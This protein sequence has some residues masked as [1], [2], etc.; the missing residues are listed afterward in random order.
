[1]TTSEIVS[2]KTAKAWETWLARNHAKSSGVWLR[3]AKKDSGTK[4]VSYA[5]ALD[6]A[7]C[8]GW[9]DGQKGKGDEETWLQRFTPR[10]ARS[11]WSRI[12][13]DKALALIAEG[14]MKAAGLAEV[15]RAKRDGRWDA[16]YEPQHTST[17]PPD[18]EAALNA[19]PAA[20]AFFKTLDSA[21]RY[22]ILWRIA[23]AKKAETRAK[24]IATFVAMLARG[25][26]IHEK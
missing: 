7:L 21:N 23:N 12:N 17:V 5:E 11:I 4:S 26:K 18:L 22:A 1:M 9:I 2:F 14:R 25:E 8:Y 20:L 3:I 16:A 24:R 19:K 15:E 6:V 10:G 13:R